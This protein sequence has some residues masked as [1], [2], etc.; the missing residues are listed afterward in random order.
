[1]RQLPVAVNIREGN[2]ILGLLR[3]VRVVHCIVVT[4]I[5]KLALNKQVCLHTVPIRILAWVPEQSNSVSVVL[6]LG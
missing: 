4:Q 1:M 2:N 3:D 6:P 5:T